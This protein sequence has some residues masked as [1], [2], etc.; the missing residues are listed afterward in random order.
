MYIKNENML[1]KGL[2]KQVLLL[3][4]ATEKAFI[5]DSWSK[6]VTLNDCQNVS[7][8]MLLIYKQGIKMLQ[9]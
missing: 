4:M 6:N 8:T 3:C 5:I 1:I 7:S 2:L 9:N